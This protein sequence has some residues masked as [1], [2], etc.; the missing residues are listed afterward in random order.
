TE[1]QT[2]NRELTTALDQQTATSEI[3]RV[4]SDSRTDVQPVFDAILEN[5]I[6][7]CG[8]DRGGLFRVANG[9]IDRVA[10]TAVSAEALQTVREHFPR[11]V[12]TT[13]FIGRSILEGRLI[14]T[15]DGGDTSGRRGGLTEVARALG[16]RTQLVAPL[17]RDGVAIGAIALQRN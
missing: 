15:S 10:A 4:I 6:R 8:A 1:L 9:Q 5:A 2:S 14:Q 11:P 12:D 13:S 16:F 7:L 3:L 17:I